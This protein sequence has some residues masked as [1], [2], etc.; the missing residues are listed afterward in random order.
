MGGHHPH[1]HAF[2]P[3]DDASV[4]SRQHRAFALGVGLNVAFVAVEAGFGWKLG[5]LALLADAGHNLSDVMSLLLA[6]GASVLATREPTMRRTYGLRRTTILASVVSAL[7]LLIAIGMLSWEAIQRLGSP[8]P[9]D[10]LGLVVVSGIGVVVNGVTAFLFHADRARDLNVRGAYLHMVADA[11]ISLGV[12]VAGAVI[13]LTGWSWFDPVISLVIAAIILVGTW[14]LLRESVDLSLDA[15]PSH[16]DPEAVSAYLAS[17]PEVS[18]IHDLHIWGLSTTEASLTVHLVVPDAPCDDS[19]LH[20]LGHELD[21]RFGI[22]H[23][24]IQVERG[25][26]AEPCLQARVGSL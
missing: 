11:A 1:H 12:V 8:R 3:A 13:L 17:L 25:N 5:S 2:E 18:E 14:S 4:R 15:V 26:G 20:R 23:V 10:G 22:G 7:L 6:W 19:F 24:T 9:V 16:I 21:A